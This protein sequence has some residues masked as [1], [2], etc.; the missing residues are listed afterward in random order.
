MTF[1]LIVP[2]RNRIPELKR[3][4]QSVRDTV[5]D[6]TQVEVLLAIDEDDHFTLETAKK[7]RDDQYKDL[8]I[9][10]HI[11]PYSG[12]YIFVNRDY[13][14]WLA[15]LSSGKFIWILGDDTVLLA[16]N[17]DIEILSQLENYLRDKPD[18]IV[19]AGIKDNTP[20]PAPHLPPFPCFPLVSRETLDLMGFILHDN[21]PTWGADYLIY[22]LYTQANRYLAIDNQMYINHVSYHT[23]QTNEDQTAKRIGHTFNML[24]MMPEHNVEKTLAGIVPSQVRKIIDYIKEKQNG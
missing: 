6:K 21:I 11:K 10:I 1:S 4:L 3:F 12:Q 18:R 2:T 7:Y 16:K 13:Y 8:N 23:R 5:N 19:C 14:N 9:T 22:Q 17:W 15:K 20:K 24:K